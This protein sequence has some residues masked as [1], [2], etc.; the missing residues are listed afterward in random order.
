MTLSTPFL[1][2]LLSLVWPIA[3][4]AIRSAGQ[5]PS[6]LC[7]WSTLA[8]V[9]G[10]THRTL[11]RSAPLARG[12]VTTL[13]IV[14]ILSR[15]LNSA[16]CSYL[17]QAKL[18]AASSVIAGNLVAGLVCVIQRVLVK[19]CERS[20]HMRFGL[21]FVQITLAATLAMLTA[22]CVA[23]MCFE[24]EIRQELAE[25]STIDGVTTAF[26]V[27]KHKLELD[28]ARVLADLQSLD[29]QDVSGAAAGTRAGEVLL[30]DRLRMRS[31]LSLVRTALLEVD[32][33]RRQALR[34]SILQ[35]QVDV[36]GPPTRLVAIQSLLTRSSGAAH[37][38]VLINLLFL[39]VEAA[40]VVV[41]SIS[42]GPAAKAQ[43]RVNK[44]PNA[45][46]NKLRSQQGPFEG[47]L[48]NRDRLSQFAAPNG[49]QQLH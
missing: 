49:R 39:A 28:E 18:G 7:G 23:L 2:V 47:S 25:A 41:A 36:L 11:M 48:G 22:N 3:F 13:S 21:M 14:L 4:G 37:L 32:Q 12:H 35:L 31:E 15:S 10:A 43:G 16:C 5:V 38:Y 19:S 24:G 45:R 9:A 17:L 34:A 6:K 1:S 42:H 27:E 46:R 26:A 33:R 40:P 30:R 29:K 20:E 44:Q 8:S